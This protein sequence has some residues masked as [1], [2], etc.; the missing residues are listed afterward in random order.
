MQE[1]LFL[2]ATFVSHDR[3][4]GDTEFCVQ[5]HH[6]I[7]QC[8]D[9]QRMSVRAGFERQP[10]YV[11]TTAYDA[12]LWSFFDKS[13]LR[14]PWTKW[15]LPVMVLGRTYRDLHRTIEQLGCGAGQEG[16]VMGEP[17]PGIPIITTL[18]R[19]QHGDYYLLFIVFWLQEIIHVLFFS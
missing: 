11:I 1:K 6:Q 13:S 4:F 3:A 18:P 8:A 10:M 5:F 19:S 9:G 2:N 15:V 7:G 14:Q 16:D 17:A 12:V